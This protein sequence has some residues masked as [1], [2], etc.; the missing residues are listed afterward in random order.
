MRRSL[1]LSRRRRKRRKRRL[2]RPKFKRRE[3]RGQNSGPELEIRFV[4]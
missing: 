1:R 2:V 3:E 4:I